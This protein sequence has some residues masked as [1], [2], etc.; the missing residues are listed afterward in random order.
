MKKDV[1]K[2]LRT[3]KVYFDTGIIRNFEEV[4]MQNVTLERARENYPDIIE[5]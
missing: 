4:L 5:V 2:D 3:G 1:I